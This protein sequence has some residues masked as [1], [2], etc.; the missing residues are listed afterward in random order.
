MPDEHAELLVIGDPGVELGPQWEEL[1]RTVVITQTLPP[2]L[3]LVRT[4]GGG[5][6]AVPGLSAVAPASD[7][8]L[9]PDLTAEERLFVEAWRQRRRPKER[10]GDGAAWDDPGFAPPDLPAH[11]EAP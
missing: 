5:L 10:R 4:S 2:R 7:A 3:A 11:P 9:P 8:E 6:P 1:G